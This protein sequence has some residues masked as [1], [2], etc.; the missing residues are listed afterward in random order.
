[1][2]N[3]AIV[4]TPDSNGQSVNH[5]KYILASP[6]VAHSQLLNARAASSDVYPTAA[7]QLEQLFQNLDK[8]QTHQ[9]FI[10]VAADR[11][12]SEAPIIQ[13]SKVV[14]EASTQDEVHYDSLSTEE[15][16]IEDTGA[17]TALPASDENNV[18]TTEVTVIEDVVEEEEVEVTTKNTIKSRLKLPERKSAAQ[19]YK[20]RLK[21]R[22][23]KEK[24][25]LALKDLTRETTSNRRS[26]NPREVSA[27]EKEEEHKT[28]RA[29]VPRARSFRTRHEEVERVEVDEEQEEQKSGRSST[30][31][32]SRSRSRPSRRQ[33]S[34]SGIRSRGTQA[35]NN[36]KDS[37]K[38]QT[39][40]RRS[41]SKFTPSRKSSYGS[42]DRYSKNDP[43]DSPSV[44]EQSVI[45]PLTTR[46][47]KTNSKNK[48]KIEFKK[49]N[50]FQRPDLRKT[51]FRSKLFE[52]R[53]GL[54]KLGEEK[55]KEEELEFSDHESAPSAL[56]IST[57]DDENI[58]QVSVTRF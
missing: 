43:T 55:K 44:E 35:K 37:I 36:I 1:M 18:G 51:L 31:F 45:Q 6:G 30:G 48:P 2:D 27:P 42:R 3:T 47:P 26:F 20:E 13:P 15:L 8:D 4:F 25:K 54:K 52:K 34:R 17:I 21:E 29:R 49:F 41:S 24:A 23:K 10:D 5:Y 56:V 22:F 14:N 32:G 50:R 40:G 33:T 28:Y 57:L 7:L 16:I 39:S 11:E 53:A 58:L 12:A 46:R 9:S 19:S 38:E